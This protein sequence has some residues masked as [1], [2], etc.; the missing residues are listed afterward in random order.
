M[1]LEIFFFKHSG[2]ILGKVWK[3]YWGMQPA[4]GETLG[5]DQITHLA[6]FLLVWVESWDQSTCLSAQWR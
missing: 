6:G 5:I 4:L 3:M 2:G 1:S